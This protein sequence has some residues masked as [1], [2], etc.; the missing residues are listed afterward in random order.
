MRKLTT[1]LALSLALG[2]QAQQHVMTVDASKPTAQIQPEMYGIFFEDINF[3]A[4]GGLYAELVKNRSFEFPQPF[5]GWVPFGNVTVQDENPCFERNPHYVRVVNDGRL[6]RAGLDNEG[7]RGIGVKQGEEYR[8]SVYARTPES[9]PMKLSVELVNS[10]AQNLLK[11]GIEVSSREWQKLT[12]VLKSPFTDAH[13][14]LRIVLESKGTVDMDHISLFP[15]KTWKGRENGLRADLAQALYD[16]NPGVFRFPGGCIIEGNSL[17]TRYQ[18][19]NSVGPVENRPLNENRWNYTFKHKAFPDYF[20]T[21]GLGFFEYFQLSEDLGAEPLPVISCGLSCQY[22]SNE[23]VPMDELGPYIQDALD[24]IEFANGPVTSTWGKVRAEM[25]HSEPFN[26]KMIAVGNEQ[27]DQ[28]Y[29]ERLEAFTKAIRAKYPTIKVVG[30]SGPSASG[31]KFDY[32]WPE[33]KRLGVDLVDEHYYM[34][35]DWFFGNASRYDNYDRKGP[36]VFAGEYASH[37]HSTKKDNNFLAALSEAAFMTGLERNADVV[38]LA[39]YAPLFAHVDAWQWN[40]DLIWFDNLRMMRTPNY[41]VQQMYGMN[42]GTDVLSLKMDGKAVAGQDSLY[43]TASLNAPTG[44]IILKL[45]NAGSKPADVRIDFNGLKK[46]QLAG[47]VCTYLQN[48]SWRTVNTLE[49]EVLVPRVRPVSAEG[50]S[51]GLELAPRSFGV[52]RLQIKN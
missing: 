24:L 30:S 17:E 12:V 48:D 39:T 18:W 23:V 50:Q 27:W 51:L 32:L 46:R 33:M 3:G 22:E 35:P 8:F 29:V 45:V 2:V 11:K 15:V 5:V 19:K 6:L 13:A 1:C 31:D 37:D 28:I 42:S 47:G 14:R 21:L 9:K 4:D 43:A 49:Q 26:L 41:Y 25:G 38:H 16:L 36:K 40:P 34:K 44:E 7:Y 52:Y 20:Q 10:D